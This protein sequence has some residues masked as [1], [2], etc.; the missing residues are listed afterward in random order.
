MSAVISNAL[1][2][3][4]DRGEHPQE[5]NALY[6][7]SLTEEEEREEQQYALQRDDQH[8]PEGENQA[9]AQ[10]RSYL[11]EFAELR[12]PPSPPV[13]WQ[14]LLKQD[15][16]GQAKAFEDA[17]GLDESAVT[18]S[19]EAQQHEEWS[20]GEE[21]ESAR[22]QEAREKL[23]DRIQVGV[24]FILSGVCNCQEK[25]RGR[26]QRRRRRRRRG[27]PRGCLGERCSDG[28]V[29][30]HSVVCRVCRIRTQPSSPPSA[31][32]T[33]AAG[34]HPGIH[35]KR[36][37]V[38]TQPERNTVDTS[39]TLETRTYSRSR[40]KE[41]LDPTRSSSTPRAPHPA[42]LLS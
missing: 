14:M 6:S 9:D 41:V 30:V 1:Q 20:E 11:Q 3:K 26:W 13:A 24:G 35:R 36:D 5:E 23:R 12:H 38:H 16:A 8:A 37:T 17:V 7:S 40:E 27:R 10:L 42:S 15:A 18:D 21:V 22:G 28:V 4:F 19:G 39:A 32:L 33:S 25:L 31:S 34:K 29:W 2:E